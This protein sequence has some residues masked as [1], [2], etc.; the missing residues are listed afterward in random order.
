MS[1]INI[2]VKT[3]LADS[4][5]T[6]VFGQR[7]Y[8]VFVPQAAGPRHILVYLVHEEDPDLLAGAGNYRRSRVTVEI[9]TPGEVPTLFTGSAAVIAA[10]QNK[11]NFAIAGCVATISKE[12]TDET[13]ASEDTSPSGVPFVVRRIVDFI[14]WWR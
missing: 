7:I 9:R 1:A 3:L 11:V 8:P 4:S 10:L 13:D 12:G 2:V 6:A 14:V 5:V